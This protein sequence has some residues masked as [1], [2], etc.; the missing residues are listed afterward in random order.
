MFADAVEAIWTSRSDYERRA[1]DVRAC[2]T[3]FE[4]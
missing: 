1:R 2:V 3:I 4:H